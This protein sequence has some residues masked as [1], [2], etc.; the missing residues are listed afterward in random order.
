MSDRKFDLYATQKL[1]KV[2]G[3][4]VRT[5][6]TRFL[7]LNSSAAIVVDQTTGE[8]LFEKNADVALPIASLTKLMTALLIIENELNLAKLI[9]ITNVRQI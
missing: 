8:V 2:S 9:K 3:N 6:K 7:K 5:Y 1:R 4:K